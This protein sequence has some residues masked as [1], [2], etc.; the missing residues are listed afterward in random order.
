MR[1]FFDFVENTFKAHPDI[2]WTIIVTGVLCVCGVVSWIT[3]LTCALMY[4]FSRRDYT[5]FIGFHCCLENN[6]NSSIANQY[7][8]WRIYNVYPFL[9]FRF[10]ND[11]ATGTL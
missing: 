11:E 4:A 5:L 7:Y 6:C 10:G 2:V 9:S 8:C 3:T 1:T